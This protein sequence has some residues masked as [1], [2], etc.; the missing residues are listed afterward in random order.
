MEFDPNQKYSGLGYLLYLVYYAIVSH[1]CMYM[2]IDHK[3]SLSKA[4]HKIRKN[5]TTAIALNSKKLGKFVA[6]YKYIMCV[7]NTQ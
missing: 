7:C 6:W 2:Y 1:T 5:Y 4:I 3:Q